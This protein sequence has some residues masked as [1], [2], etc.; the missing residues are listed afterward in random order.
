VV[1]ASAS[2]DVSAERTAVKLQLFLGEIFIRSNHSR[3]SN[4]KGVR[5]H[6]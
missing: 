6:S 4:W 2:V 3:V 5:V 1:A